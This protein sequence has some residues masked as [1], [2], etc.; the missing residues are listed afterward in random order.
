MTPFSVT[1][2]VSGLGYARHRAPFYKGDVGNLEGVQRKVTHRVKVSHAKMPYQV[3]RPGGNA[4]LM[5]AEGK[6][7]VLPT[8]DPSKG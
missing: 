5:T 8:C 4:T 2:N 7:G 3:W 6:G 1:V